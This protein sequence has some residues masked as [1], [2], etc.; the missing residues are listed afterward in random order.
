MNK[1]VTNKLIRRFSFLLGF[2]VSLVSFGVFIVKHN[3]IG[4]PGKIG[5]LAL[6]GIGCT[7]AFAINEYISNELSY[8]VSEK[9]TVRSA[10]NDLMDVKEEQIVVHDT[11]FAQ[12]NETDLN[13]TYS[14]FEC[15]PD[16]F[17]L[18]RITEILNECILPYTIVA[19]IEGVMDKEFCYFSPCLYGIK[20]DDDKC[21]KAIFSMP[22]NIN[23]LVNVTNH[24]PFVYHEESGLV[25]ITELINEITSIS[26]DKYYISLNYDENLKCHQLVACLIDNGNGESSTEI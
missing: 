11:V 10:I 9:F 19:G 22:D 1:L 18:S 23:K 21:M 20:I 24:Y 6:F 15:I 17:E 7:I 8:V 12:I 14:G 5:L 26:S 2:S 4:M 16:S 25:D 13:K 3:V